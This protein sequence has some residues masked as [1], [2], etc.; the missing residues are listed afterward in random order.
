MVNATL[1]LSILTYFSLS[2]KYKLSSGNPPSKQGTISIILATMVITCTAVV[3]GQAKLSKPI[4][5]ERIKVSVVQGNIDAQKKGNPKKYAKFIMQKYTDL[6]IQASKDRTTLIVWPE[7]STPGLVL[8]HRS[9]QRQIIKLIRQT[10]AYFLIGSSE[11]AKFSRGNPKEKKY[12]NT[13]LFFSPRGG[14]LGHYFKIRLV[15]FGEYV[16]YK[17]KIS[18]PDYIVPDDKRSYEVPGK[19]FTLFELDGARFGAVICWEIVFPGLVRKFI[20]NGANFML[21]ISNEGWFGETAAPYQML[22]INVLRAVEN[23]ISIARAT[24][25]GISCFIDPL[26]NITGKVQNNYKDIFVE[27]YLTQEIYLSQEKTFYTKHGDIFVYISFVVTSLVLVLSF[28]MLIK[29]IIKRVR[30]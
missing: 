24:N 3:Y 20:A 15:P 13:A 9:L 22:S 27:G 26:G 2:G 30:A 29:E 21:N 14:L 11:S 16:P 28:F 23:R 1:A 10:N 5:G 4:A 25:T 17:E 19:E 18:W 12:G 6:S 8:E 7:A